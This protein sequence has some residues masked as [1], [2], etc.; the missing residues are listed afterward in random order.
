MQEAERLNL[1]LSEWMCGTLDMSINDYEHVNKITEVKQLQEFINY[2]ESQ[3]EGKSIKLSPVSVDGKYGPQTANEVSKL[4]KWI[5]SSGDYDIK[6]TDGSFIQPEIAQGMGI[7]LQPSGF[8]KVINWTFGKGSVESFF[9]K[10]GQ[11]DDW[12]KKTFGDPSSKNK[13]VISAS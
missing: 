4:K 13:P 7:E 3:P 6:D 12:M 10:L 1:T 11:A 2:V 5:K 9:S 8:N